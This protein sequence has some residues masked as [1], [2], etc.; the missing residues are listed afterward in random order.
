MILILNNPISF[1]LGS[2]MNSV[3]PESS[4]NMLGYEDVK[5][6]YEKI[7]NAYQSGDRT[8]LLAMCHAYLEALPI[9]RMPESPFKTEHSNFIAL[10]ER[11]LTQGYSNESVMWVANWRLVLLNF[12]D[13]FY[14]PQGKKGIQL[15]API[16][17]EQ[18]CNFIYRTITAYHNLV[19]E[20]LS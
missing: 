9:Q 6:R 10:A 11:M 19:F 4:I 2:H 12:L 17:D 8:Q 14:Y 3:S 15:P 5:I 13:P 7:E 20:W 16:A 1:N 18:V